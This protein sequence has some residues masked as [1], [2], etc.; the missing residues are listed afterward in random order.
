MAT[1]LTPRAKGKR[2]KAKKSAKRV[3]KKKLPTKKKKLNRFDE[4]FRL[5][6]FIS[7]H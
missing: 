7:R 4:N 2:P 1:H 5:K 6:I 3:G